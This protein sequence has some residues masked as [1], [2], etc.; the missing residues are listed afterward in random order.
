MTYFTDKVVFITG[1]SS[2]IGAALAQACHAQGAKVVLTARRLDRIQALVDT[3]EQDGG[4]ALAVSCDVTRNEDLPRAVAAALERFGKIDIVIAN[5][6]FG[7]GGRLDELQ[8]EDYQRQFDT[9]VY[10]VLRTLFAALPAV[11]QSRGQ[12]VLMG[13]VNSYVG[14]PGVS[15]YC[16]SKFALKGLADSLRQE[17]AGEGVAVTLIC[18]GFITTEIRHRNNRNEYRPHA[19]DPIPKWIQMS[20]PKAAHKILKAVRRRRAEAVITGHGKIFVWMQR[21]TPGLIRHLGKY[22]SP[23]RPKSAAAK[24]T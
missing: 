23:K 7:V 1:A 4:E 19:K 14:L 5:A 13:S 17:L 22:F 24:K 15:A 10:G 12:L 8:L 20:A 9:N 16:M 6:G 21:L 3:M 18:P 11:K 2:G